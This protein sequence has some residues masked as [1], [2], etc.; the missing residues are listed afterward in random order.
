MFELIMIHRK[1]CYYCV[2]SL[3]II[4]KFEENNKKIVDVKY[5][6]YNQYKVNNEFGEFNSVP[7]FLLRNK[8]DSK[9]I[10]FDFYDELH[11]K[12]TYNQLVM[13]CNKIKQ[14]LLK[15]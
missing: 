9:V 14:Q 3:P 11:E 5:I 10:K 15:K 13:N 1:D 4:K 8:N 7:V 6:D 2:Q 12:R